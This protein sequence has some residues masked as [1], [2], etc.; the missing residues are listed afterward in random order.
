MKNDLCGKLFLQQPPFENLKLRAQESQCRLKQI[1]ETMNSYLEKSQTEIEISSFGAQIAFEIRSRNH[2][3]I[4]EHPV[5]DH[6]VSILLLQWS[7]R[8][9]PEVPK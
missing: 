7:S 1:D 8:G 4:D 2:F 6:L 3:K 5:L 9:G